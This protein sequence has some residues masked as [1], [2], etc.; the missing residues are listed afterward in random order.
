[1]ALEALKHSLQDSDLFTAIVT[2]RPGTYIHAYDICLEYVELGE[3]KAL[4]AKETRG[5]LFHETYR[6]VAFP[7][8]KR[9]GEIFSGR[10]EASAKRGRSNP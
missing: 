9:K 8:R 10:K 5:E 3:L 4:K 6:E 2:M 1:M 7:E